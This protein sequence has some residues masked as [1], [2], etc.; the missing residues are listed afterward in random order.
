L[1]RVGAWVDANKAAE[2][3]LLACGAGRVM[4]QPID[5]SQEDQSYHTG[6]VIVI[7]GG[8]SIILP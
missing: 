2:E 6:D 3:E 1:S 4:S 8:T 5:V 7:D